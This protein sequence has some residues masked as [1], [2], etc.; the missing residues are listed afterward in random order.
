MRWIAL[1]RSRRRTRCRANCLD[2]GLNCGVRACC[3]GRRSGHTLAGPLDQGRRRV[4][5]QVAA[6][7]LILLDSFDHT[8]LALVLDHWRSFPRFVDQYTT[9][10]RKAYSS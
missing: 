1:T 2:F 10:H 5:G 7:P 6:Q 9:V 4:V 8:L 3:V